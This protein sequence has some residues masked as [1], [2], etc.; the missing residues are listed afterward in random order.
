MFRFSML[1]ANTMRAKAYLQNLLRCGYHPEKVLFLQGKV[2]L[3][4]E[5]GLLTIDTNTTQKLIRSVPDISCTVDEKEHVLT[6]LAKH[7]IEHEMLFTDD[8]NSPE[9]VNMVGQLPT[10]YA[11]YAGPGGVILR[12]EI[13]SCGKKFIH[14][15][16]G[17][18]PNYKGSTTYYY[19]MLIEKKLSCSLFIMNEQI[20][21]GELLF[22]H[23]Y[24]IPV[25]YHNFDSVV[26]P[27]IRAQTLVDWFASE[28]KFT[29]LTKSNK[30]GNT[31]YIIHPVLKHLAIH[32][33]REGECYGDKGSNT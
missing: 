25:G 18:L 20:D 33:A 22:K 1:I 26:D 11:V 15:H 2:A 27:L 10:E 6:T 21:A 9:V 13:L 17:D 32:K 30:Q 12:K 14:V 4:E 24:D 23:H 7:S 8:V 5:K 28:E 19:E 3:S 16:P 29:P 31:F